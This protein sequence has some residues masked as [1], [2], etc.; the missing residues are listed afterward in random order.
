MGKSYLADSPLMLAFSW[1]ILMALNV[2]FSNVWGL[3]LKE[4]KGVSRQTITVLL[5]GV[6]IL[7][8]SVFF[9]NLFKQA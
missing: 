6:L 5:C 1:S 9:P 8:F 2:S 7:I 3:L 4:W